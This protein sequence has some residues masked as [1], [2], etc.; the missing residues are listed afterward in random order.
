MLDINLI[1]ENP[2]WVKEQIEKLNDPDAIA[3]VDR[4]LELDEERRTILQKAETLKS[5]KN[6]L[7]KSFGRF[8]G[9]KNLSDDEKIATSVAVAD[10]LENFLE[11]LERAVDVLL[12]PFDRALAL[13]AEP[14]ARA[15]REHGH[16][17][18]KSALGVLQG[19]LGTFSR[20]ISSMDERVKAIDEELRETMLWLPNMPHESV[21]VAMSDE[22][23]IPHEPVGDMPAFDFEPQAHWDIG[24]ALG[25][26][27]F[28]RGVKLS[29]TRFYILAGM[30]A[31]LHRALTNWMLDYHL[32]EG[33]EE[34]YTPFMVKE[35]CMY[36]SAQ[37][38]KFRDVVYWDQE[39]ELYMLPTAEVSITNMY[40][41]EILDEAALPL[42]YIGHTPCFR[43]EKMS[44]GRDVRGIKRVHQFEKV[45]QYSFTHPDESY[46]E[47]ERITATSEAMC[48]AL[49]LPY[50]R[51]EIVTGDLGF[52][53]A[54][55][56]DVEVYAAGCAEWLEV[57]SCSN[58]E[59]F[60]ARRAN[61]KFRPEEGGR[62]QFVH[63][64]NGS[65][66]AL[67]RIVI[68]ILENYQQADGSVIVP[69]VL[70]P[71]LGGVAVIEQ[72]A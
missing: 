31:R 10:E 65:G 17:N 26:I 56:Y 20:R 30:G 14:V 63:T 66:L 16:D 52:A 50:R 3:R 60:Q 71:Y 1:R 11:G 28:E 33:R 15:E 64:L 18:V 7:N 39:A 21:P 13:L 54:K 57:S 69:E 55:K 42:R 12:T 29:G 46:A 4:I 51:L 59:A 61:I 68:A 43:R 41:G 49:G 35:E 5:N 9:N 2:A 38:P 37:F 67:P 62:A 34:V 45:E 70:R 8:R 48:A 19:S 32:A 27:D 36:G 40:A 53:A 24:P 22:E 72:K 25:I 6:K 47:L 58:T 44:A 23:N